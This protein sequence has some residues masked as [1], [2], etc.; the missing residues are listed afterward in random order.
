MRVNIEYLKKFIDVDID[1]LKMK[2]L[3]CSIGIEVSELIDYDGKDILDVEITPNR[4]DWLSHYGIARDIHSK[5]SEI[6]FSPF[7]I[8]EVHLDKK[9]EDFS[10]N[11][12]DK[13][14]C[15]R[16]TGCIVR[17]INVNESSKEVKNLIK[18]FGL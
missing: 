9:N 7:K 2:N 13:N 11:I 15:A 18:S 10:I 12:E 14:D 17:D 16:Y 6:K 5:L 3:L 4:P 8:T 1:K